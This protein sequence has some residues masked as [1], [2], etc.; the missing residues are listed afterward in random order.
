MTR[1]LYHK[2]NPY[3][4]LR[5]VVVG[6]YYTPDYFDFIDL[7]AVA[8]PLKR[9]AEEINQD[10]EY[11]CN[12][13]RSQ[14][15]QIIRPQLPDKSLFEE[16]HSTTQ[17]FLMPPLQPR[18]SHTVV[19]NKL[20]CLEEWPLVDTFVN[21]ALLKYNSLDY[22]DLSRENQ[23]FYDSN[24]EANL[25]C[26]NSNTNVWYSKQKYQELAG[27][28]WPVFADYVQGYRTNLP[29]IQTEL[30]HFEQ[31][32][33]YETKELHAVQ[34]PNVMPVDDRLIVDANEYC[35][36]ANWIKHHVDCGDRDIFQINTKASHSDGCFVVL[37]H[38]VILGIDPLIDYDR[39][40]PGY[41]VIP[42]LPGN[43]Q[44]QLDNFFIMKQR[45]D[46]RWWV[47]GQEHNE[48]FI[49]FVEL[50]LKDWTGHVY[51]TVFDVN[52]LAVNPDT[53]CVA[54]HNPVIFEQLKQNGIDPV[55]IPWRHRFFVD[56][57]LHCLTLDLHRGN[58]L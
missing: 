39:A 41:R 25:A 31:A 18:D 38:N 15:C 28:D 26:R 22:V 47:P 53:V 46:G 42:V 19:G 8:D 55:V 20:Y 11:F 51:E 45:V 13:L 14:G 10:L 44:D 5:T 50:Y 36:Y 57:G 16:H 3:D 1:G 54:N 49:N 34:G 40:F 7:P 52:V 35:N 29:N 30:A 12:F 37:G 56:C 27:P 32:L 9:I 58:V 17:Q 2:Q 24:M 23:K 21:D 33:C 48:A 6:N 43:Y 4:E